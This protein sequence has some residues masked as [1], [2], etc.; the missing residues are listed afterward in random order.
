MAGGFRFGSNVGPVSAAATLTVG[1]EHDGRVVALS[2]SGGF[3]STLP[4]ST[5]G[6]ARVKFM[7]STV[8]TTGYVVKVANST[9]IMQG[10]ILTLS[11]G[12]AAVL[13]YTAAGT[14]DTI[15]LNGTTTGG[16]SIG[17]W[18]ELYDI[19]AGTWA[20][21]GITTSTGIEATPFSATV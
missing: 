1:P 12:S 18:V 20:V 5:G 8:S 21:T 15:T 6:G 10:T 16:V 2:A 9:D 7:V 19:K 4:A 17:D 3:T 11:D 13:G 14:S